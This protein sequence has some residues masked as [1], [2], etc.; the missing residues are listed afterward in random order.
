M[1]GAL[2][3]MSS[4]GLG[5]SEK[6]QIHSDFHDVTT[7]RFG[8]PTAL[9]M[10]DVLQFDKSKEDAVR[11][12]FGIRRTASMF[13]GVGDSNTDSFFESQYAANKFLIYND[14]NFTAWEEHPVIENV[15]WWTKTTQPDH[16][17]P[18][19]RDKI[20]AQWGNIDA[21]WIIR[22][23]TATHGSGDVHAA[24]YDFYNGHLY[25]ASAEPNTEN[26]RGAPANQRPYLKLDM[27]YHFN[28]VSRP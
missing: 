27:N 2:T 15:L 4:A 16:K 3:G 5:V 1:V 23:W 12:G 26:K 6:V 28:E 13:F 14:R 20:L 8:Y 21:E 10:K 19:T 22:E 7:T 17:N 9:Y 25:A 11:R 24:V 18:C